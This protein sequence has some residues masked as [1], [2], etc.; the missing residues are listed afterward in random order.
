MFAP[1]NDRSGASAAAG[2]GADAGR[3]GPAHRGA[4]PAQHGH[5]RRA[6]RRGGV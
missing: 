5:P 3:R 1:S 4:V 2:G 6:A